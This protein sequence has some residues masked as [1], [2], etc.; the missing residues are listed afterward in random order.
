MSIVGKPFIFS[1]GTKSLDISSTDAIVRVL[2]V[3]D[4]SVI[5]SKNGKK[6]RPDA[7][8]DFDYNRED[9]AYYYFIIEPSLFD[10]NNEWTVTASADGDTRYVTVIVDAPYEYTL[11]IDYSVPAGF[12]RL[13]YIGYP[14]VSA[15]H[16]A[17]Q[18][19]L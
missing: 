7:V 18:T 4:A 5:L 11:E 16:S 6:K 8:F 3:R 15:V 14:G 10:S 17:W 1:G 19:L 9:E 13:E 12:T 2:A